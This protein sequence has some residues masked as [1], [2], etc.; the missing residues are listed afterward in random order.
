MARMLALTVWLA[1][2]S[3]ASTARPAPDVGAVTAASPVGR[4]V[5]ILAY[6]RFGPVVADSMTVR[7][8]TLRWQLR[9]LKDHGYT[10]LSLRQYVEHRQRRT[11]PPDRS[12]VITVD[13]AHESVF[14]DMAP[15]VREFGVPVTLFLYPS[16]VSN[17]SYAMTW[18]QV[19]RLQG[20]GLFDVQSHTYW[21]PNFKVERRRLTAPQFREFVAWQLEQPRKV[22]ATKLGAAVD[23]LSWPFGLYDDDLLAMAAS[24]GYIA[25]VTLDPRLAN[26]N[27]RL[28]SLPRFLVTDRCTGRAFA[29]ML[30]KGEPRNGWPQAAR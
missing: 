23:L 4:Q 13:D 11:A 6:H 28:L 29:A 1:A 19:A 18:E 26:E 20:T 17:A 7:T 27:D 22:I 2:V 14:T 5:S 15:L 21:H 16:A 10:L 24:R 30:P 25:G 12:V 3:V 8:P 9:Y